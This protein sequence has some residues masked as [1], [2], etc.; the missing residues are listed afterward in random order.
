MLKD[1]LSKNVVSKNFIGQGYYG[2]ITPG[3][4]HRSLFENPAWYTAYTPYQAEIAQGRMESLVNFQTLVCELTGMEAAN[5]S[6][7][8]E[9]TAAAEAMAMIARTVNAK[10][11]NLFF[12]SEQCHPQTIE[13]VVTRAEFYGIKTVVG[14]HKNFDFSKENLSGALV[15][16]PDTQGTFEDYGGIAKTI[17][18][19]G[20]Q[21]VVAA[22][23]LSLCIARPPADFGADIAV[24]SMQ[25]F[26]VPMLF[27]GPS[28][29]Y[30]ACSK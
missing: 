10:K 28:A 12:I 27:G 19:H 23:P 26:G 29:A 9:G 22:D 20:G 18:G 7:L 30:F 25:R 8:D 2:T 14:D 16:Y 15:Q 24:G 13:V 1:I 3:V 21:L 11:K 4:I 17:H 6:L 5:A